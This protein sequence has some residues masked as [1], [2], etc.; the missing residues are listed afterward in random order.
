MNKMKLF[1]IFKKKDKFI[2]EELIGEEEAKPE[3]KDFNEELLGETT[4][5]E[6]NVEN[7]EVP[8]KI[9]V[10]CLRTVRLVEEQIRIENGKI[11]D[12]NIATDRAKELEEKGFIKII[13]E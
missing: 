1:D 13:G 11:Y 10:R 2:K 6:E 3:V 8:E 4:N 5:T 7:V 9:K 12:L